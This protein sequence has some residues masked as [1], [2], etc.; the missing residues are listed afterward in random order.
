MR[1]EKKENEDFIKPYIYDDPDDTLESNTFSG[2]TKVV[3]IDNKISEDINKINIKDISIELINNNNN[4]IIKTDNF[5][6]HNVFID[7][8]V[9]IDKLINID[10]RSCKGI[11]IVNKI[12][13]KEV[14]NKLTELDEEDCSWE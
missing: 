7:K 9:E 4:E 1:A 8:K 14:I 11:N 10:D 5:I 13:Y 3:D 2:M 6:N 12:N